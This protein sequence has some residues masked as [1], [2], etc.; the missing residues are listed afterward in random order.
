[1]VLVIDL[2]AQLDLSIFKPLHLVS[3]SIFFL[4]QLRRHRAFISHNLFV[5]SIRIELTQSLFDVLDLPRY[6][7]H[8]L[9]QVGRFWRGLAEKSS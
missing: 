7:L 6:L 9:C 2:V 5:I 4:E 1:M 8:F 3:D